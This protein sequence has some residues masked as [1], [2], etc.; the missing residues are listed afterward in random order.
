MLDGKWIANTNI[1]DQIL[2]LTLEQALAKVANLNTIAGLIFHLNYYIAGVL[3]V[4]EGGNLDIRDK[5]SFDIPEM[6]SEDDWLN[7]KKELFAN[8][9]KF[10]N[11]VENMT[12]EKLSKVFVREQ[13]GDY[14]RNIE[15]MTEH[16]YYHLGQITLLKK[17]IV[18]SD[19][20]IP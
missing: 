3:K 1:K 20:E 7:L 9:E 2:D 19:I 5:F 16:A 15:A 6:H 17:M 14:R 18:A 8:T 10:A 12:E 11:H 13:Y 4:F